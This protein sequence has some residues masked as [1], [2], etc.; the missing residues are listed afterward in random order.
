MAEQ[1]PHMKWWAERQTWMAADRHHDHS[2]S[3]EAADRIAEIDNRITDTCTAS[4]FRGRSTSPRRLLLHRPRDRRTGPGG[5]AGTAAY[6]D[7]LSDNL[8]SRR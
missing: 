1:D 3:V 7:P 4:T 2:L 8:N 5:P 6:D